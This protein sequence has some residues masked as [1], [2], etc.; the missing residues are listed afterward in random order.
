[1]KSMKDKPINSSYYSA[2]I[3]QLKEDFFSN[4][5]QLETVIGTRRYID[6]NYDQDLNLDFLS[7]IKFTSKFH[8]QRLFK[9]YYGL[10]PRQY[11][12][13]KRIEKSKEHL[14]N[15]MTVT[16][17]CYSVGFKSLGSF[18]QLFKTKTGYSP[19]AYQKEQDRRSK[20]DGEF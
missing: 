1:M 18:S 2:K 14:K 3:N 7:H 9:R 15:G 13:D 5:K 10:T 20:Q 4:E 6:E 8:L 16:E 12:I 17:T 19:I 11:L